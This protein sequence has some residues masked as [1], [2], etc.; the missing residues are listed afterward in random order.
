MRH[1]CGT[2]VYHDGRLVLTR[3]D[4]GEK[5]STEGNDDEEYY[6][7]RRLI[8]EYNLETQEWSMSWYK[9]PYNGY[10]PYRPAALVLKINQ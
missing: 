6:V 4:D 2:L 1:D 8:E 9:F 7:K 3:G 10:I 5:N